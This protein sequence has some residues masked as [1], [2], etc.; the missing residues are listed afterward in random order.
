MIK[1]IKKAL[2][3]SAVYVWV[4]GLWYAHL[5]EIPRRRLRRYG[6]QIL[7]T[8]YDTLGRTS[9]VYF[10]DYGTMLGVVRENDFIRHDDD[11]DITI[12]AG[13]ISPAELARTISACEGFSFS[14]AFEYRGQI[15]EMTF[16]Y[17]QIEVDFF[18][19]FRE[20]D[21]MLSFA[22][23]PPAGPFRRNVGDIWS[24][25]GVTRLPIT[26][27]ETRPFKGV[28]VQIPK[29]Y[30]DVLRDQYGNWETPITGWQAQEKGL[31]TPRIYYKDTSRVVD[32]DRVQK[33]GIL[34]QETIPPEQRPKT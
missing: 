8:V 27:I 9:A 28:Y 21:H 18:F 26:G 6:C 32:F 1:V 23:R 31:N 11:V 30:K 15:T 20:G 5:R 13:S 14:H 29:N 2:G 16:L 22:Y 3:E 19:T 10:V 34:A 4:R 33:V 17:K 24:A 25:L 12:I 7:K